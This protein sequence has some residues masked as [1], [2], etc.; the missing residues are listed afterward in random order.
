MTKFSN[1]EFHRA[2]IGVLTS[3]GDTDP[4]SAIYLE[5]AAGSTQSAW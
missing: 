2:G 1:L 4:G 3:P 5:N